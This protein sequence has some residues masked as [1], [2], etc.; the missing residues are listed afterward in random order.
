MRR[1]TLLSTF[2]FGCAVLAV[3]LLHSTRAR[4]HV[5]NAAFPYCGTTGWETGPIPRSLFWWYVPLGLGAWAH[6]SIAFG[7]WVRAQWARWGAL[8][9]C[10]I[11]VVLG[12]CLAYR[13]IGCCGY[14][15]PEDIRWKG[16]TLSL[17]LCVVA[18]PV[19]IIDRS[20]ERSVASSRP[21]VVVAGIVAFMASIHIVSLVLTMDR[22]SP[23]GTVHASLEAEARGD[24][25][26][27]SGLWCETARARLLP[28]EGRPELSAGSRD[29]RPFWSAPDGESVV[30]QIR[31]E[32]YI[33]WTNGPT[34][35]EGE[36]RN[37]RLVRERG[38][39]RIAGMTFHVGV[40][41]WVVREFTIP[42][43]LEDAARNA[44]DWAGAIRFAVARGHLRYAPVPWE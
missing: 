7:A 15:S 9:A 11:Q 35:V 3:A 40:G 14:W 37:V 10:F 12:A 20:V 25:E 34:P 18:L 8:V 5:Q 33:P 43:D 30:V 6:L 39:W 44:S 28:W 36:A 4:L 31:T 16:L 42:G 27:W 41:P 2:E 17:S 26:S 19:A 24:W 32:G 22:W 1:P 13:S 21:T 38:G 29:F 23:E